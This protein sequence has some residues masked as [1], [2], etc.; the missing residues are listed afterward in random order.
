MQDNNFW[1]C[2]YCCKKLRVKQKGDIVQHVNSQKHKRAVFL[3]I[4]RAEYMSNPD[5]VTDIGQ[6]MTEMFLAANI[7]LFKLTLRPLKAFIEGFSGLPIPSQTTCRRKHVPERV[8]QT[9][10]SESG[11]FCES[12]ASL[13]DAQ[14]KT[15]LRPPLHRLCV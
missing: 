13:L 8:H 3:N 14:K 7:P 6:E 1:Y 4:A 5:V 2:H 15:S 11:S 9:C 10:V 12:Q